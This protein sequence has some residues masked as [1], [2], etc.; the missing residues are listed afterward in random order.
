MNDRTKAR[1]HHNLLAWQEGLVLVKM[2]YQRTSDFPKEEIFGLVS[3]MRRAAVSI[4]SNIA[5]G[6]ARNANV[7][8][9]TFS[10]LQEA[11]SANLKLK[12]LLPV[13]WVFLRLLQQLW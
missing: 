3:Q 8:L 7:N 9:F 2:V 4:P 10:V 13:I 1:G 6:A 12:L 5:E 11:L